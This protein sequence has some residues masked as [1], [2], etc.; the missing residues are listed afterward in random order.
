[1]ARLRLRGHV[2]TG[3]LRL[4][5]DPPTR[6]PFSTPGRRAFS[7]AANPGAKERLVAIAMFTASLCWSARMLSPLWCGSAQPFM[8]SPYAPTRVPVT[9]PRPIA[10]AASLPALAAAIAAAPW[11]SRSCAGHA[12]ACTYSSFCTRP[13]SWAHPSTRFSVRRVQSAP[14]PP[15]RVTSWMRPHRPVAAEIS[16][17]FHAT[18]PGDRPSSAP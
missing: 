14:S 4:R 15:H 13:A 16:R 18:A 17:G 2:G 12:F 10:V 1:M 8:K 6:S 5:Q 11:P 3:V 9:T 7:S